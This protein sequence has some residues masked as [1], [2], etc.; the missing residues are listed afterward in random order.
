MLSSLIFIVGAVV[1]ASSN[2][3]CVLVLGRVIVGIAIGSS[4]MCMPVYVSEVAPPGIV[5]D[6][7]HFIIIIILSS[8][9]TKRLPRDLY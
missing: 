2:S 4:S 1:L 3:Y 6:H 7:H 9:R 8:I 5:Y